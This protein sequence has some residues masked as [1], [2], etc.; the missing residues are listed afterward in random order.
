MCQETWIPWEFARLQPP[1]LTAAPPRTPAGTAARHHARVRVRRPQTPLELVLEPRSQGVVQRLQGRPRAGAADPGEHRVLAAQHVQVG[2]LPGVHGVTSG[3]SARRYVAASCA[4]GVA[5]PDGLLV[6]RRGRGEVAADRVARLVEV[7]RHLEGEPAARA[8]VR[9]QRRQQVQVAPAPTGARRW[10][11]ARRPATTGA[12]RAGRPRRTPRRRRAPA[13]S[14]S[15]PGTSRGRSPAP[16]ASVAC[17]RPVRLPGPQ[18]RSTTVRGSS[19]PTRPTSST[20][21]RPRSSAYA[22]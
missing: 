17:S 2:R 7:A 18:P 12:S 15:S 1:S 20:N 6:V 10:T 11:P 22:R 5:T 19:A 21:G 8:H 4:S 16:T 13:P 3:W 9:D 14:R